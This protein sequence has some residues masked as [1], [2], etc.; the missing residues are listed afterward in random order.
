MA[1][2]GYSGDNHGKIQTLDNEL[3]FDPGFQNTVTESLKP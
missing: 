2:L 1:V 3:S